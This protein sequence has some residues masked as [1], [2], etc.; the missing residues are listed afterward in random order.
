MM[1]GKKWLL[2]AATGGLMLIVAALSLWWILKADTPVVL[3]ASGKP[4]RIS[5]YYWPGQFWHDIAAHKGWFA[6][7]GLN[8]ELVDTNSDY[9][10][11]LKMTA[12]GKLDVNGFTLFDLVRYN[13]QG[14]ELVGVI[15]TDDST[16][17]DA[18]VA[19]GGIRHVRELRGRRVGVARDSY[20]EYI[21]SIVLERA[22][23][24]LSDVKLVDVQAEQ[25]PEA[26]RLGKVDAVVTWEPLA[27]EALEQAKG[28][29]IFDS[30]K[31]PGLSPS[32]EVFPRRIIEERPEDVR[33]F[34]SVWHKTSQ[35]MEKQPDEA[36]AIIAAIYKVTPQ[37]VRHL[38]TLDQINDYQESISGFSY[39]AGLESLHG[40]WRRM[41]EFIIREKKEGTLMDSTRYL[42]DRFLRELKRKERQ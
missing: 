26:L 14:A 35:Y 21:L 23:L 16:G 12:E 5:R 41:N 18:I 15:H 17:A 8:V 6:E 19:R 36:F 20:L 38:A 2:L 7:A 40:S 42:D 1:T 31:I 13:A 30:S 22:G 9:V 24:A 32:L 34:V 25:T 37:E 4:L 28:R 29:R 33:R 39:G 3:K 11:S 27:A 10:G